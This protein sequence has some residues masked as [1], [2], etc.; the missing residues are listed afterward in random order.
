[1][2][3]TFNSRSHRSHENRTEIELAFDELFDKKPLLGLLDWF[4]DEKFDSTNISSPQDDNVDYFDLPYA[5]QRWLR[6]DTCGMTKH[7]DCDLCHACNGSTAYI[8]CNSFA[9]QVQQAAFEQRD[10]FQETEE[11]IDDRIDW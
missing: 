11:W 5:S 2:A 6:C 4:D 3:R 10:L 8:E 1:M 9:D 7:I